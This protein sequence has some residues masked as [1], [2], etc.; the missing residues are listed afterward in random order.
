VEREEN[1]SHVSIH[2]IFITIT[3]DTNHSVGCWLLIPY[4]IKNPSGNNFYYGKIF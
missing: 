4:N 2:I 3:R 1:I